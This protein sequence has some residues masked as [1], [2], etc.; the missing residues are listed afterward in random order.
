ML[1][2]RRGNDLTAHMKKGLGAVLDDDTP[3]ARPSPSWFSG[4]KRALAL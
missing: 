1:C 4:E 3:Q 2:W